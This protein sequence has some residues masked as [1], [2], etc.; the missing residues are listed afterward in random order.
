M[1]CLDCRMG[2][3]S[4]GDVSR[5]PFVLA[6]FPFG[7]TGGREVGRARIRGAERAPSHAEG[8]LVLDLE[9]AML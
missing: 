4:T 3:Q 8:A 9:N 5:E 2:I 1:D 7:Y 6:R